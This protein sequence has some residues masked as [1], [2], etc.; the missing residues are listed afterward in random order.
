MSSTMEATVHKPS[1]SVMSLALVMLFFGLLM[2]VFGYVAIREWQS[3]RA[4]LIAC[5]VMWILSGP[6]ACGSALWLLGYLGRSRL[7][8]W[9][10]GTA[11]LI[12]GMVLM[13]A[14]ATGVLPCSGPA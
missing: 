5:G 12:S 7:A 11:I 8:L 2:S 9:A 1:L 13:G 3:E 6:A 10:G 4:A 14:A